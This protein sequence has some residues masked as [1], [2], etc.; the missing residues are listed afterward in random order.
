MFNDE[1]FRAGEST[2]FMKRPYEDAEIIWIPAATAHLKPAVASAIV[3][4]TERWNVS[5]IRK[6][7]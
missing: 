3:D 2:L 5:S 6:K 4:T 7:S 1:P